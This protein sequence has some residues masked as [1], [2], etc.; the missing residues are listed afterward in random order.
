MCKKFKYKIIVLCVKTNALIALYAK[1]NAVFIIY[2]FLLYFFSFHEMGVY[3]MTTTIDFILKNTGYSKLDVVGYSLGT[4]ISLVC[5]T[6]R[7]EYNSK[8]N[9]LVLM[10]PTSRLKSSGM[11]LK[12]LRQYSSFLKVSVYIFLMQFFHVFCLCGFNDI[13]VRR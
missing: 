2:Y 10:A 4:T 11:P 9:K 7:P 1:I 12:M 6:D 3:D 8:I 5:L 13:P